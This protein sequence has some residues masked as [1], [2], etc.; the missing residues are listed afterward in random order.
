MFA[1]KFSSLGEMRCPRPCRERNA[2]LRPSSVP[3]T[4]ASD[5][6]PNGVVCVISLMSVRP[7]I[8]YK[9]L[10]PM[11][12]ISACCNTHAPDVSDGMERTNDYT[13]WN[14]VKYRVLNRKDRR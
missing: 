11:I 4:Y 14:L 7:G 6:A 3:R 12:P 10:P 1:R 9:P 8:E 5:G 13:E 2:T